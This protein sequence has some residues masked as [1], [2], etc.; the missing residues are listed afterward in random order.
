VEALGCVHMALDGIAQRHE[1]RGAGPDPVGQRR[2]V[3]LAIEAV[4]RIDDLL[5]WNWRTPH[6]QPQAA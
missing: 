6:A 2:H 3:E 5:P 1:R 4:R